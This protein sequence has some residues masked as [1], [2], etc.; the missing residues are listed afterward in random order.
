M[1]DCCID[2]SDN[3]VVTNWSAVYAGGIRVAFIKAMQGAGPT[4][5]T[6]KPQSL[7]A[8]S[9]NIA[10]IP[11][12]FLARGHAVKDVITNFVT[13]TGL[14][15]GNPFALDWEGRASQTATP[16]DVE[17]IGLGIAA[18]AGR[19]PIG[20]WGEVGAT[21]AQPTPTMQKWDRWIPRY[22]QVPQP[23]NIVHMQAS[24]LAKCPPGAKFWQYSSCGIVDGIE[25]PVDRSVWLGTEDEFNSWLTG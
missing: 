19:I 18:V 1:L 22:P 15:K 3:N 14:I 24:S 21:P 13:E 5:P 23:P 11:Y 10:V 12:I 2:V 17:A 16:M 4:Y 6:W 8:R 7:G 25:G 9:A 20:Y